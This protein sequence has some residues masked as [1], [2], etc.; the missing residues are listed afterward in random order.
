MDAFK[1]ING[2]LDQSLTLA[3]VAIILVTV[4]MAGVFFGLTGDKGS[5]ESSQRL[6]VGAACLVI[7]CVAIGLTIELHTLAYRLQ[8]T[9]K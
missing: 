3:I 1:L 6:I 4:G 9:Q 7:G 2:L 5:S 8:Q